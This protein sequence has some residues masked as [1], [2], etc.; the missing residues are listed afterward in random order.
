MN[1]VPGDSA[2]KTIKTESVLEA[3]MS[4]RN[5]AMDDLA[6][7]VALTAEQDL[8]IAALRARVAELSIPLN[9]QQ[10]GRQLPVPVE[11]P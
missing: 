1:G 10:A 6:K 9:G 11:Q 7:Y 8:E 5:Q 2:P 4:Q 3:V